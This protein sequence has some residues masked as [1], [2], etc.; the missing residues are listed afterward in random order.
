[1]KQL[2]TAI[3]AF[4]LS[5][6]FIQAENRIVI[7]KKDYKLYVIDNDKVV[8]STRVCLGM[9][10]GNKTRRGDHK[11]PEGNFAIASIENSSYW[12]DFDGK[13]RASYGPWFLRLNVP[14]F[15][16]IGIHG[17]NEPESIGTR[18]SMGC[19]RL[20]NDDIAKLKEIV[21]VGTKVTILKENESFTPPAA[22]K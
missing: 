19:V 9:N 6:N 18:A 20:K 8:F 1:M 15:R 7:S 4:I 10:T 17:T 11:T 21:K 2:L 22:A 13:Y 3:L 5:L 12:K 16:A 14:K